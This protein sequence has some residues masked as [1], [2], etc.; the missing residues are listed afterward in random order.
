MLEGKKGLPNVI[1][2]IRKIMI[3]KKSDQKSVDDM[4]VSQL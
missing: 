4:T 3:T 1:L 2:I